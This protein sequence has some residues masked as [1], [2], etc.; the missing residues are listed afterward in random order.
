[1]L[2]WALEERWAWRAKRQ[3]K[4]GQRANP[5]IIY[6]AQ[7]TVQ[8]GTTCIWCSRKHS[9]QEALFFSKASWLNS[10]L[11][12]MF[13]LITHYLAIL[14][15]IKNVDMPAFHAACTWECLKTWDWWWIQTVPSP[16]SLVGYTDRGKPILSGQ[17]VW[18]SEIN[19]HAHNKCKPS[20]GPVTP[21]LQ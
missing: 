12:N 4:F 16:P 5:H 13:A 6:R 14:G 11:L 17:S 20:S 3:L 9:S 21:P 1:M 2:C 8:W 7:N 15:L 19:Q 18:C 10:S